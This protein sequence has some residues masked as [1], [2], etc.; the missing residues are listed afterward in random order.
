MHF[1]NHSSPVMRSTIIKL[2]GD[3]SLVSIVIKIDNQ[4]V[5]KVEKK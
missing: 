2:Q 5:N 1:R 4:P 3:N